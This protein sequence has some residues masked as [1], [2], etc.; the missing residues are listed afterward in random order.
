LA[1]YPIVLLV[2]GEFQSNVMAN[3]HQHYLIG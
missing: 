3:L 1:T 2:I